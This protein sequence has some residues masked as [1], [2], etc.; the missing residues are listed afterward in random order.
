[1]KITILA[2]RDTGGTAYTLAH[3]INHTT[4]HQAVNVVGQNTFIQYPI[5][6]D[7]ANYN[8]VCIRDMI[9]KSDVVMFLGAMQPF[10]EAFR[11]QKKLMRGKKKILLCMGSEWRLGR[12][13]LKEQADKLLGD[14]R[15]VLGG[16]D[17]Y[18]PIQ[19][20][21]PGTDNIKKFDAVDEKDVPYLPVVRSFD[22]IINHFGNLNPEDKAAVEAFGVPRKR[23]VFTHAPTSET[24]K[25][26]HI[27]YK[28]MTR[29]QQ[30]CGHTAFQTVHKQPWATTLGILSRSDVLF[31]Q[32]PPF[33][34][35]YGALSVEAGIFH[36]PSFSQVAPECRE[37]IKRHTGLDTPHIVFEDEEDL[38]K[39]VVL[40]ANDP[41]LRQVLGD[42]NYEYCRRL[43][44]EKPVVERFLKIVEAM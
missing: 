39:K 29:V 20:R 11:L 13:Q 5:M 34:T 3:A 28:A 27:F 22:E 18:Q 33:P 38:F 16:A 19:F 44:D 1:M 30:I 41:K 42:A 21:E 40:L 35:A 7:M 36:L 43:H 9:Y 6:V 23:V 14:Y 32:A 15:I 25:G 10:F 8:R 2:V 26:S 31:D 17:M 37:F 24:N 12:D 4:P